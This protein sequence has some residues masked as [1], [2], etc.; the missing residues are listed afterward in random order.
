MQNLRIVSVTVTSS[1]SIS[2]KFTDNLATGLLTSNVSI[3]AETPNVP[4]SKVLIVKVNGNILNITCQPLTALAS[5][6]INFTSTASSP[7]VSLNG[8]ARIMEGGVSNR[9]LIIGPVEPDNPVKSF[10]NSY[11][12]DNIY[13]IEDDSTVVSKYIRSLSDNLSRALYDIRQL[14]NENYLSFDIID[15][16]KVRGE[17]PFDRLN[18]GGAYQ[19]LRVGRTETGTSASN[20]FVFT[21]FPSYPITLQ[22]KDYT[23]LLTSDSTDDAGKFNINSL[24]LNLTNINVTKVNSIT[25]TLN[26]A[27]PVYVY[28]ISL[29]GYQLQNNRYDQDYGFTFTTLESNQIKLN[30]S[31]LSDSLFSISNVIRV[32]V[33]Y[34]YKNLGIV[35]DPNTVSLYTTLPI[36]REVIPPIINVFTLKHAPIVDGNGTLSTSGGIT[37]TDPNSNTGSNHPAFLYEITFRLNAL[38]Y[39]VGQYSI[40][41]SNGTVYVYGESTSNDGTGPFP[42]L[43]TYNYKFT[44]QD[45]LDYAYDQDSNDVVAI[46]SGNLLSEAASVSFSY[47]QVLIPETDYYAN[48]HKEVLSERIEN[49][50]LAIN[51]LRT[52]NAPIT[53]VFRVINETSGEIYPVDR[54]NYDKV[55]FRANNSPTISAETH[56]RVSFKQIVNELLFVDTSMTNSS[57]IRIMKILLKNNNVTSSTYD[58]IGASFNSSLVLS[59]SNI[60]VNEKWFNRELSE[61]VNTDKLTVVG[62]YMID[63]SNGVI[64]CAALTGQGS[65][66]GTVTYNVNIIDTYYPH[67]ISVEDIYYQIDSL[68]IKNKSFSY[69]SFD[70]GE[71]LPDDLE[72]TDE[73]Y[74]N[75]SDV[76]YQISDSMIGAFIDAVFVPGV[77][78]QVKSVRGVYEYNDLSNST[79]PINFSINSVSS[80]F[81]ITTSSIDKSVFKNVLFDGTDYYILLDDNVPYISA[82]ITYS[83]SVIRASDSDELW[84]GSGTVVAGSSLKLVLSGLNSPQENDLVNIIYSFTINDLSRVVVDYNKGDLFVDYTYLAD[85]IIVSYEYGD[86]VID[87]RTNDN[88][89]FGSEYYV[90]Y[91]VGAL[92]DA[93]L[94]NFGN[95]VNIPELT[96]FDIDFERERYRDAL[97]AA[98]SSF[99]QGP[100]VTAIKNIG[101]TI[102]H[103]EPEITE[104]AFQNWSLGNSLLEPQAIETTG[105]F[106][107]LPVKFNNGANFDSDQTAKF[108]INSNIRLEEGTFETWI[109]PQWNGLDNDADVTFKILRDGYVVDSEF[110]FIGSSEYHPTIDGYTFSLN[111]LSSAIGTPNMNKDGIFIYYD[112][113]I[114]GNFYRWYV[115]VIDGYVDG[116]SSAYKFTITSTG[117]F[118]D[119]KGTVTPKPSNFTMFSGPNTI[120]FSITSGGVIE[121]GVTFLSDKE[122]YLLDFGKEASQSRVSIYKDASGYINLRVFD[123]EKNAYSISNDVSNWISGDLHHVA[124]SWKINTRNDRDELHLFIDGF[125]VPNIIK[126]SQAL[127]PFLH[128]KFR[129]VNPEEIIGLSNRDILSSIDLVTT[130]GTASVSSSINFSSYNIFAG[131][132]VH[133]DEVGFSESGYAIVSV[134]GQTLVLDSLMPTTLSD[135][136]FTIN[137]TDF[138]VTSEIEVFPNIAVTTIHASITGTDITTSNGSDIVTSASVNFTTEGVLAGDLIIINEPSLEITYTILE[139]SGNSLTISDTLDITTTTT[140]Q[141]YPNDEVEIPG[142]RAL[143]PAYSISKDV[144]F[145]NILTVSNDVL[146]NDLILIR[147]LGLNNKKIKKTYYVWSDNQE[148]VLMTRMPPPISLDEANITKIILPGVGIGP[149]NSTLSLGV[150]YSDNLTTS[151]P[152]NDQDGR[153]ISVTISGT[154]VD[155]GTSVD[156]TIDGYVGATH[157]IETI[158]FTDYGILD[159]VNLYTSINYI[160]VSTK[161]TNV[162]RNAL[163]IVVKEKYPI[164]YS[165]GA[166]LAPIIRYSYNIAA[167]YTLQSDGYATVK[168]DNNSFSGL[169]IGNYLYIQSPSSVAGYYII[170][171]ISDDLKSLTIE[172]TST[173]FAMPLDSFTDGV[174]QVLNVN[175][176]RSG[177][178]NGFFTFEERDMPGQPYLLS[179]GFYEL[180]Y[181]TYV[182]IK[183]DPLNAF[184]YI[185]S[186]FNGLNQ[187]NGAID[188]VKIYST[189]L[190]DTR[191]GE[192]IPSNQRSITK[193]FN[194]LKELKKD[195]NTLALID[196]DS[197]PFTN[198]ADFIINSGNVKKH[199]QSSVVVNENFTNSLVIMDEPLVIENDGILDTKKE[200][201]IEFWINPLYDTGNDPNVRFYFDAYG[202]TLEEVTS[203]NRTSVKI[204]SPASQILSVTL[205]GGDP[206]INYFAGGKLEIDTQQAI[207]EESLSSSSGVV[208]VERPILQVI[209][210]K[211]VGDLTNTD[212][213]QN[214]II[215]SNGKTIY[216]GKLLPASSLQTIVTYKS[217]DNRNTKLN[218]QIIRL[219]KKLPS[220]NCKVV[221]SYLPEGLQGDR[222]S[223]YKDISGSINFAISA[224][225]V[226]YVVQSQTRWVKDT[227][228]RVKASYKINSGTGTDEMRLFLDGY[229]FGNSIFGTGIIAGD[230]PIIIG[231]STAGDG[232]IFNDNIIFKDPI[233]DLLIGSQ[234]NKLSPA[235]SMIDNFRISNLSRP[236]YS[237]YG[238]AI[239][240]NYSSNLNTVFPVTE[241]LY[242]TYLLD[243]DLISILNDDF[244]VIKNR[245]T[246]SFD[247]SVNIL[248]FFG[249][250]NG[251]P[252]VKEA[253]EKL[254]K[255]LKPANSKV[256]IS[257]TR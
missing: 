177:L 227:W 14:K 243:F 211:I 154:N 238:E 170:T 20:K 204:S 122:H 62:Q 128:E 7:F 8:Q 183:M 200:A 242:T 61:I 160:T 103:I 81:D 29:L 209:S 250:V 231:S 249:I 110:V 149:S 237:P 96:N 44:Y 58:G 70:E 37:F 213:F 18:E 151:Q 218:T 175:E 47:E 239:D 45:Q 232:Y 146:A 230:F 108:P 38:P 255:V 169:D 145:N 75:N 135:G 184:A 15:E 111:K 248:D 5:Y 74:I 220:Q 210:V 195:D 49:K 60:F 123:K 118:Y 186:D 72:L 157:T 136:K 236:I 109:L 34:E 71:I 90:T 89:P 150:F 113:D 94:K 21:E 130:A 126:Y 251:S 217:T 10:F 59:D 73:L 167:G 84:D 202:A 57:S 112:Q 176:Y 185:G 144:N 11:L 189:M 116:T 31:I 133:I 115:N 124:A 162:L 40:D 219:N 205:K 252:K 99:I 140:F 121:E 178:Q 105:T 28:D 223:I 104:S 201:T 228:H 138:T 91:K 206:R 246:G 78:N 225:G 212:Y 97:T 193:D 163:A 141:I 55:Y 155:F 134:I 233:N 159:F 32:E 95:L 253:L 86:N 30:D 161:P 181:Y 199:F 152:T 67:L 106:E 26:T 247:F 12:K 216:L 65:N 23:E 63:Y 165:E 2:V 256:N 241:D 80:G 198:S 101:K 51:A 187:L 42:P 43:A 6:Y 36:T 56:E 194:S 234:Y 83:F 76:V 35:V 192:T 179:S 69:I 102:S 19:V 4:D 148:N 88:L 87:F 142:V 215:G 226:D 46:S 188:Q 245:N 235:F 114:S 221:V 117:K 180:E 207:Q 27:T 143:R 54:W 147:T 174:Y 153:T 13:K 3:I 100:T 24:I 119:S 240:V 53:N 39:I 182:K 17:G 171:G 244:A 16:P 127:S 66:I 77:T 1:S 98:M 158:S 50:L 172:S 168:D 190:T 196:F 125:E 137:R 254:I 9:Y 93:L 82:D 229:E 131:D 166:D 222:V 139:V 79:N 52:S 224:S 173:S 257:Y 25:F 48:V 33:E 107:L 92:R 129:T 64:Y 164:T 214:G 68:G 132:I 22:K 208:T 156:V 197:Y 85:E 203:V 191:T 41:Y 120:N